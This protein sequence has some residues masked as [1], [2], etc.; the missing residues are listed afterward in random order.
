MSLKKKSSSANQF[1]TKNEDKMFLW[2]LQLSIKKKGTNLL[3]FIKAF[4]TR[5]SLKLLKT[6]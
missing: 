2:N 4:Q 5:D 1:K 6:I 3:Y